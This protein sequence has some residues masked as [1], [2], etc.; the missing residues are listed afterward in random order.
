MKKLLVLSFCLL[1]FISFTSAITTIRNSAN[2]TFTS[3]LD[4]PSYNVWANNFYGNMVGY[5]TTSS[6]NL[7][8]LLKMSV[9]K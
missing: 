3:G 5:S 8:W 1:M 7:L 2:S 6:I 9:L 4:L